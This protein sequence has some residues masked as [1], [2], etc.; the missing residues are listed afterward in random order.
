MID[1]TLSIHTAQINSIPEP[2]ILQSPPK[3][4]LP[5]TLQLE[6]AMSPHLRKISL[7]TVENLCGQLHRNRRMLLIMMTYL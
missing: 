6:A 3:V 7:A 4:S 5:P 1:E 2:K